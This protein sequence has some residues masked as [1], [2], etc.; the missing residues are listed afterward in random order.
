MMN[1]IFNCACLTAVILIF[2][3]F[4][5]S[6]KDYTAAFF[7]I[8]PGG[9]VLNTRAIQFGI[10]YISENGGGRLVFPAGRY[11]TGGIHFKS[12]VTIQLDKD[13]VLLGSTNPF[14]YDR[15]NTPFDHNFQT[16]LAL[17]LGLNQQ[18]I[19]ITGQGEID[20][21]GKE[22][23][24]AVGRLVQKGLIKDRSV[25]RPDEDKRPMLI[26]LFGCDQVT[27]KNITLRNSACW[28]ECYNQCKNV[29]ID[30]IK[31]ESRAFW[32]NDGIDIVDCS[33]FKV[34]NSYF[35]SSDDGICLKSLEPDAANQNILI[36]NNRMTTDASGIKFGTAS[37]GGF[38][39]IR[40][41]IMK[42]LI[43][44][45][46][47][48]I[49]TIRSWR[50]SL[51]RLTGN[52]PDL[53]H[54]FMLRKTLLLFLLFTISTRL[55]QAQR[56]LLFV[57]SYNID[58][59]LPGIYVYS[60]DRTTGSLTRL[61]EY[62]GV[63]NPSYL[64]LSRSGRYLYACTESRAGQLGSVSS[65]EFNRNQ[66]KFI[67]RQ[68]TGAANPVY[69]ALDKQE[70]WLLSGSYTGGGM[71]AF[72]V[73]KNGEI[74]PAAQIRLFQDS[75]IRPQQKSAHI[76]SVNFSPDEQHVY[77]PDLG[78]DK[79]RHFSFNGSLAEP[80]IEKP[81]IKTPPGSGPRHMAFQPKGRFAYC[82][83]ELSGAVIVYSY[84]NGKLDSIQEVSLHQQPHES[85]SSA[86]IHISPDCR[87]L[88]ASN[89]GEENNIAI[90][91]I[92][93]SSGHLSTV[94]YQPTGGEH[95]R[96][97]VIDPSGQFLLAANEISGDIVVF[98]RNQKTGQL[99]DTGQKVRIKGP[100]CLIF[101]SFP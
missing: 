94:G 73:N 6:A 1:R 31:V 83:S 98:R 10:N 8:E 75:S 49:L 4:S 2:H 17:I 61:T 82:V 37:L 40:I 27:I 33:N 14:D 39:N 11:L 22:L 91:N 47:Q 19:G 93:Q 29:V 68:P 60:F 81:A 50:S 12:N 52:K 54:L 67:S 79:I 92:D 71:A 9:T 34:T 59:N 16:S 36:Q 95:P 85:Y 43:Q 84:Q 3:V 56:T 7:G 21:Q 51:L 28:V 89:R 78:A 46:Q 88:Y 96:N 18:N 42:Y 45:A 58:K 23:A 65:F 41:L 86:D 13:A 69:V 20:G 38:R 35:N 66:L 32:N 44:T 57:G 48:L 24:A 80:L 5:V 63:L 77:I 97:F 55:A 70:N 30:S 25:S 90:F 99:K 87:F 64:A 74:Q 101:K 72:A 26:N 62:A 100:S 76:H 53:L 15:Q